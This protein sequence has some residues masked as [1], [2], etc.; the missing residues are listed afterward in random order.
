MS[1]FT[2]FASG[3]AAENPDFLPELVNPG[4]TGGGTQLTASATAHTK[5]IY[6]SLGTLSA[7]ITEFTLEVFGASGAGN[8]YI[9]YLST[10]AGATDFIKVL[11]SPSTSGGVQKFRIPLILANGTTISAAIQ[12]SVATSPTCS[13]GITGL[14]PQGSNAPGYTTATA[15]LAVDAAATQAS[16][17][18]VTVAN[19]VGYTQLT[20]STAAQYGAFLLFFSTSTNPANNQAVYV[21]L[22]KGAAASEVVI[23]GDRMWTLNGSPTTGRFSQLI[24]AEVAISQRLSLS[25]LGATGGDAVLVGL[26]GFS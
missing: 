6:V 5:G 16:T 26:I 3:G 20:P 9:V 8:R 2:S 22:A 10:D 15:I 17:T 25:V 7:G 1:G 13:V 4:A 11:A 12:A 14:V 19:T 18:S 23:G 21:R 24:N